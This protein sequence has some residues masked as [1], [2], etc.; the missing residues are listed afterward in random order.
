MQEK[1]AF[2]AGLRD[3]AAEQWGTVTKEV[4]PDTH[5]ARQVQKLEIDLYKDAQCM[6]H[7][8]HIERASHEAPAGPLA[9]AYRENSPPLFIMLRKDLDLTGKA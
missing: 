8:M 4:S 9:D 3:H 2:Q 5:L 1:T 6:Q 7:L